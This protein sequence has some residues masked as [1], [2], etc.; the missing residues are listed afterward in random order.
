MPADNGSRWRILSDGNAAMHNVQAAPETAS[1]A[2]VG[3]KGE[4]RL[5]EV[6]SDWQLSIPCLGTV[7]NKTIPF[8]IMTSN[9][10]RR[11]GDPLRR[12]CVYFRAE[13][14]TVLV[15]TLRNGVPQSQS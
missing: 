13:F 9:E 3:A 5:L 7:P 10:V 2:Q 8:V 15:D 12:R 6:L 1:V 4:R 11:T 14:P